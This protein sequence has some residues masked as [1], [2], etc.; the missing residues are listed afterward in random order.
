M[1]GKLEQRVGLGEQRC[2]LEPLEDRTRRLFA[3]IV[4]P[5]PEPESD[6]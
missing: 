3:P 1:G 5:A 4:F 2:R 6:A